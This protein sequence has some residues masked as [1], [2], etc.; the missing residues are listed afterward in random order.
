[1]QLF[2]WNRDQG[3]KKKT[4]YYTNNSTE[5]NQSTQDGINTS[6]PVSKIRLCKMLPSWRLLRDSESITLEGALSSRVSVDKVT[7]FS[8][9]PPELREVIPQLGN[10]YRWFYISNTF[11][12]DKSLEIFIN[13]DLKKSCWIDSLQ[14]QVYIRK[15]AFDE[16][17]CFLNKRI[18]VQCTDSFTIMYNWIKEIHRLSLIDSAEDVNDN[19]KERWDFVR[20]NLIFNDEKEK[21]LLIPVFSYVKPTMGTRFI[22][23]VLLSLGYFETELDLI[24]K[25]SIR[26]SLRYAKL[27]GDSNELEDLVKYSNELQKLFIE[28]QLVYFPNGSNVISSWI[29]ILGELFDAVIVRDE[30]PIND[31]PPVLQTKLEIIE[32]ERILNEIEEFQLSIIKAAYEELR[33]ILPFTKLPDMPIFVENCKSNI[34]NWNPITDMEKTPYQSEN[35]FIEQK[36]ALSIGVETI[37]KYCS[38]IDQSTFIKCFLIAGSPGAGKT[39]LELC[40]ALYAISKGLYCAITAVMSKRAVQLGGKHIHKLF[41]LPGHNKYTLYR[42]AEVALIALN[43]KAERY[44]FL[45]KI[46]ILFID[47]IGQVSAEMLGTLD[48]ILRKLRNNDI[49][50]GGLLIISTIDHKQLS[51]VRGKPFL[52]SPHVMTCFKAFK[53]HHSVRANA[54]DSLAEIQNICRMNPIEYKQNPNLLKKLKELVGSCCTFVPN[55]NSPLITPEVHRI[56][57]KK[58]PAKQA[59]QEYINQVKAQLHYTEYV[60]ATSID[61]QLTYNSHEEWQPATATTSDYLDNKIKQPRT[62][63]FF[64]GAQFIFTYN[65]EKKFSQSQLGLL[66]DVPSQFDVDNFKKIPILV[67]PP[68][69]KSVIYNRN[70]DENEYICNGWKKCLVGIAPENTY[71][72]QGNLKAQRKQY[73]LKPNVTSTVHASMG[74]TLIKIATEISHNDSNYKL[75]DKAQIVVIMS[76]TRYAKDIIFVGNKKNTILAIVN[77]VQMNTQWQEYMESVLSL[78]ASNSNEAYTPKHIDFH[79]YPFQIQDLP[80][81]VCNTGYVYMILSTKDHNQNYIGQ[82]LNLGRRLNEH[83]SGY[84]STFTNQIRYRPWFLLAYV[85]GFDKQIIKMKHFEHRWQQTRNNLVNRGVKDPKRLALIADSVIDEMGTTNEL[86][87]ILMFK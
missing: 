58:K 49:F 67:A 69:I 60:Q 18:L 79:D 61:V 81:P 44:F 59:S 84:G 3:L 75:W 63:L 8:L 19:D 47:E 21:H 31:M 68:G 51:P 76:R 28:E 9:R 64:K 65:V 82:T 43:R 85:V 73:G 30:I 40:L 46:N 66:L 16:V 22:L 62:L 33:H 17:I 12:K 56:Y 57:G 87:L 71:S 70:T 48:V 37:D 52:T 27:I 55:W 15:K 50:L 6:L 72:V 2:L 10:Y 38:G 5:D 78:I 20:K 4:K 32:N 29:V 36:E 11:I 41:C 25:P 24:L 86:R 14:K 83:N 74:D 26:E 77:L 54:D 45:R 35:S 23:H 39:F 7:V 1:M 13:E 42:L 34:C 80:L 53:L